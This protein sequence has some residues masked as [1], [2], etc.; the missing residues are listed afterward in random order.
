[1]S[2]SDAW[3]ERALSAAEARLDGLSDYDCVEE[4]Q[5][6][7]AIAASWYAH[8]FKVVAQ[9]YAR[10]VMTPSSRGPDPDPPPEA[11]LDGAD[12]STA[13]KPRRPRTPLSRN[14]LTIAEIAPKLRISEDAARRL[15]NRALTLTNRMPASLELL[16]TGLIDEPRVHALTDLIT[17]LTDWAYASVLEDDG[18]PVRAEQAATALATLVEKRVLPRAP[19]QRTD[20]LRDCLRRAIARVAPTYAASVTQ[21]TTATRDVFITHLG[22]DHQMGFFGAH[23]PIV[24]AKACYS[25]LNLQ[26]H[27]MRDLGDLRTLDQL[28]ADALVNAILNP[29]PASNP[30]SDP[31]SSHPSSDPG[32]TPAPTVTSGSVPAPRAS[33]PIV[34][35]DSDPNRAPTRNSHSLDSPIA[36]DT[37]AAADADAAAA[38][39]DDAARGTPYTPGTLG[40]GSSAKRD[41]AL[42]TGSWRPRNL[43]R[44]VSAHVQVTVTLETLLNLANDPAHLTGYGTITAEVARALAFQPKSTWRRLI[45]DPRTGTLLD[46]GRT[47]YRPPSP[48]ADHVIARDVTC[49]HPGCTRAAEN[50]DLDHLLPFPLGTTCECNLRPRCRRH[51]RIKH[52]T[53]W[54]VDLSND[55]DDPDGTLITVT[56]TGHSYKTHRPELAE[57]KGEAHATAGCPAG[58]LPF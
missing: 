26:A 56:P 57:P 1:M 51:H 48:L 22:Q 2:E 49:A 39:D 15:L 46:Y 19:L 6:A 47:K 4:L 12:G 23:L 55:T 50:C 27:T 35:P 25:T 28:R 18:S 31:R 10:P 30:D 13:K 40:L 3:S 37:P 54:Q 38:A 24:E 20:Q 52:E 41:T 21:A 44:G 8:R 42:D 9:L 29:S 16:S 34:N 58:D 7:N 32:V 17:P 36:A 33:R 43:S 45:T 11:D 5:R 53:D 14:D